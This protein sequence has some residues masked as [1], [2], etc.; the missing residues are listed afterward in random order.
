M[1]YSLHP[2]LAT[3][4]IHI[5]EF[6]LS[7]VLLMNDSRFPWL[8]LVPRRGDLV[9]IVDLPQA[10]RAQLMEEIARCSDALKRL[11]AAPKINVGAI[12]N[13]VAQLH[14]HVVARFDTDA[15]WPEAVW[16]RGSPVPYEAEARHERVLAISR[17]LGLM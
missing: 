7:Q 5:G 15:V 1:A 2:R 3:D 9:E 17:S 11:T 16:G 12:G 4:A 6:R 8:V 10:D 14:I 13:R